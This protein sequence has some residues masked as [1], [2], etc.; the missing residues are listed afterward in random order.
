METG[1]IYLANRVGCSA[2]PIR[3]P[4]KEF[5][6]V[7][8]AEDPC[9]RGYRAP[10]LP[11]VP[12]PP[13]EPSPSRL[14]PA[15]AS[16]APRRRPD[17]ARNAGKKGIS[18]LAESCIQKAIGREAV[19]KSRASAVQTV[20]LDLGHCTVTPR[21][22]REASVRAQ[23]VDPSTSAA[24]WNDFQRRRHLKRVQRASRSTPRST[25]AGESVLGEFIV[26][27]PEEPSPDKMT[28]PPITLTQP[29]GAP[30]HSE[31][32]IEPAEKP[33]VD[34]AKMMSLAVLNTAQRFREAMR[35]TSEEPPTA[36][37]PAADGPHKSPFK[38]VRIASAVTLVTGDTSPFS[39]PSPL[40][41]TLFPRQISS[42][43]FGGSGA[44]ASPALW[45]ETEG[46]SRAV[47][48]PK[49]RAS[50]PSAPHPTRLGTTPPTV[51]SPRPRT[52][53]KNWCIPLIR[54]YG[55]AASEPV[56]FP[57]LR[58]ARDT[59][60][61]DKHVKHCAAARRAARTVRFATAALTSKYFEDGEE[62]SLGDS[63]EEEEEEW[64]EE[65]TEP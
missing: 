11:L 40:P 34:Q 33:V 38:P 35:H 49:V 30:G 64:E 37:A 39:S 10:A 7:Y 17:R 23:G 22:P 25:P 28:V 46:K 62:E 20:A 8:A 24:A 31:I 55:E 65:Q 13:P 12:E 14:P 36:A 2:T 56:W 1:S 48:G 16:A 15:R 52:A 21:I 5:V 58:L 43:R 54:Y 42:A 51:P 45:Y 29:G 18:T 26:S 6:I 19:A 4:D 9:A 60:A 3:K 27:P 50:K 63:D 44:F 47:G 41:A 53:P 32:L 61:M 59:T 57:E